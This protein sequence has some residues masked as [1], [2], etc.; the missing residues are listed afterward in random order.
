MISHFYPEKK[1][2]LTSFENDPPPI[3]SP[4]ISISVP[5]GPFPCHTSGDGGI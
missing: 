1:N 5:Q 3:G 4:P 2:P